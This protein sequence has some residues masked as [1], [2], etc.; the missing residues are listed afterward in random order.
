MSANFKR[1]VFTMNHQRL[2]IF[3]RNPELGKV[4]TRLA[5]T[6]GDEMALAVYWRLASHTREI[7]ERVDVDAVVYY[8][9]SLDTEDQWL[10]F[11]RSVQRGSDL[12]ERMKNAFEESFAL[13]Y[14]SVCII[15]TDCWELTETHLEKAFE[16]CRQV[17]VVVGPAA[18]GGYY[19]LGMNKLYPELFENKKWSTDSVFKDTLQTIENLKISFS[20]L[21]ELHD[22]DEEKDLPSDWQR[23]F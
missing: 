16:Q 23:K 5:A 21:D 10:G 22:V 11:D 1:Y 17:D 6:V 2:I 18:D 7:T 9:H 3:Y 19:L 8:S 20:V 13:G 14:Q 4:K 15:G 12:G